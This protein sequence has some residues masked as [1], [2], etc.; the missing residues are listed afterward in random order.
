MQKLH[1][2]FQS[3][4]FFTGCNY[5]ASHA[6]TN[7]WSDWNMDAVEDDFRRLS[8][9]NVR[10]LRIFPL[11][12]DFQPIRM[13]YAGGGKEAEIRLREE[14]LPFTEAG[15]AGVDI[16]MADRFETV[17]NL[18]LKYDIQLIVGLVTGWMS[19]R[20][21]VPEALQGRNILTDPMC[22]RWQLK[23]IRYMVNRFKC[24]E[25]IVAWDLGNECNCL[26]KVVSRDEAYVWSATIANEIKV[27][28]K[29]H[30]LISGMHGL[31]PAGV[32]TP[33]DQGEVTDILCTHPYPLFTPYCD[34]DPI[35]EMKTILHASAESVMYA[36]LGGKPCFVEEAGT[37]GPMIADEQTAADYIRATMFSSWA[38]D[39]RGFMWWCANE[40]T[41]L[42]HTPYDWV[43]VERELGLFRADK[44]KKP[45]LEEITAFTNFVDRFEYTPLKP[46]ICDA[47]CVLTTGQDVWGA[48][49]G[50]FVLAKQAGLDI[51]YA[52]H[53]DEIPE[54]QVYL[55]PSL[56][57]MNSISRHTLNEL[58]QKVEQG[59]VM[60][61]S[62]NDAL[63]SPF[64]EITGIKV[65]VRSRRQH[66]DTVKMDGVTYAAF[67]NSHKY[68]F[69]NIDAKV[70][71]ADQDDCPAFTEYC[72]GKGKIYFLAF[73]V[74]LGVAVNSGIVSGDHAVP[75]YRFY[76]KMELKTKE[77]VAASSSPYLTITEHKQEENLRILTLLN[78]MPGELSADIT[79]E[80]YVFE[81][82]L[83]WRGGEACESE[84]GFSVTL[85]ANTGAVAVIKKK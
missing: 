69:E 48:A 46:R 16:V 53:E 24:H 9:S 81:R 42:S 76:E 15:R 83:T 5:W 49:Y 29:R 20:L 4:T 34:S 43:S 33:E 19:G 18:A 50:S 57:G 85:P 36:S 75:Y 56:S 80:G 13:H 8:E 66:Q 65:K 41:M 32:W 31:N 51:T 70:L 73:P 1:E 7:M 3:G 12:S 61:L 26:G 44:S 54:A 11:W 14:P 74:E 27:A 55:L 10:V 78:H 35:N 22:I 21:F 59:A 37:L 67:E 52:W 23:F 72:Y 40:Q 2:I 25:A 6:G 38:H 47:V 39:L 64:K 28:D 68:V 58:L 62:L 30:P 60:Y 79:L 71:A 82:L 84:T 45:V 77:K 63:L 17:C